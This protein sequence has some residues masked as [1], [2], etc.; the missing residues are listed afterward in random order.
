M[1]RNPNIPVPIVARVALSGTPRSERLVSSAR[2]ETTDATPTEAVDAFAQLY[3]QLYPLVLNYAYHRV[4]DRDLA[5][6]IVGAAFFQMAAAF[7]RRGPS[8]AP[9]SAWVYRVVTNEIRRHFRTANRHR[10]MLRRWFDGRPGTRQPS[11]VHAAERP[12]WEQVSAA[13]GEIGEKYAGVLA[14]RYF[15]Q[16]TACEIAEMLE[17]NESTVRS[18]IERGLTKLRRRL[19]MP[20]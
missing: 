16:L 19:E 10:R 3:N 13:L 12:A 8:D 1:T 18:R 7:R 6:D 4:R 17:L 9:T 11:P 15:E 14:L 2:V 5:E 20:D